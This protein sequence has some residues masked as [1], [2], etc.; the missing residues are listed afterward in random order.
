MLSRTVQGVRRHDQNDAVSILRALSQDCV[1]ESLTLLYLLDSLLPNSVIKENRN[2]DED[3]A[4]AMT[5]ATGVI[6]AWS[7]QHT[8]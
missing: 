7:L 6:S 8:V 3:G 1:G 2:Q 4:P 5:Y